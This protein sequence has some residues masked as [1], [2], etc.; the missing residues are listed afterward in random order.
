VTWSATILHREDAPSVTITTNKQSVGSER[1]FNV[2][3]TA[4]GIVASPIPR[5]HIRHSSQDLGM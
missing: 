3:L 2:D 5:I 4:S 1:L